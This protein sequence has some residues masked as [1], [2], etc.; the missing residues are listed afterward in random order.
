M[1]YMYINYI[2][3]YMYG[4]LHTLQIYDQDSYFKW[5]YNCLINTQKIIIQKITTLQ[6]N[7]QNR[8]QG[9]YYSTDMKTFQF[10]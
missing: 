7:E 1:L 10:C 2:I 5:N 6:P 8:Y 3:F 4:M 9:F